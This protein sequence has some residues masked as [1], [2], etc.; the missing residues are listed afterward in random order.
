MHKTHLLRQSLAAAIV[1]LLSCAPV[2]PQKSDNRSL[3]AAAG[4]R[5]K[6]GVGVNR[7]VVQDAD[8]A[9]LIRKHF[10]ILT[11][12]NCMKPQ[13]I[14][15]EED[16]WN[17]GPTD[18]FADFVRRH[19]L[20][21]VG[22]CL[23]WAKDDRTDP[24][25]MKEDGKPVSR[26]KLLQRIETHVQTVVGRYADVATHWDVVNEAIGDSSEGLLRDSVYSRTTGMDFIVTA[27]KA[28]RAKDP[29]ALLI[30][31]DYN[32]H[33]PGKREKLIEFLTKLKAMDAPIDAYGMQGHFELGDNSLGQ[34]R[35][36]FDELRKL[37]LKVVV[38]ELD[39]D[40]V[41]RGRWWADGGKYRDELVNF[42]PYKNG[43]PADI[44][45]QSVDQYVALFRMFDQYSDTIA[46]VSFW[47]L[48]DGQSW[49]NDF[50]WKRKN[51]PLLFDRSRNGKLAFDA[52][53]DTLSD[54]EA[55]LRK[56][57][58]APAAAP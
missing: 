48:H 53:Y 51:Y 52:V 1:L 3:K 27:F 7:R 18:A 12:E 38:S 31:N 54:P 2:F 57:P 35:T 30:Y 20:E 9:E 56:W 55:A 50:P 44:E 16:R 40:I 45:K 25:M 37:G 14:H 8:D 21:M 13:G 29:D 19:D 10:Q 26:Q 23:V 36:T 22:H 58:T 46:R 41:K 42:D 17:F 11:P 24:W 39:I 34:L 32:G 6:M 47:N 5:F 15:P 28:A 4:S 49:L 43:V 33:K